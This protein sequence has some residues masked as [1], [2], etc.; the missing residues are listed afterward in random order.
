MNSMNAGQ[1]GFFSVAVGW[2]GKANLMMICIYSEDTS[3]STG[4]G[5]CI[6]D[7]D[8]VTKE[9]YL[10][11]GVDTYSVVFGDGIFGAHISGVMFE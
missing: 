7:I 2:T 4:S 5:D 9:D 3:T 10:E 6:Y 1:W 8:I 11:P